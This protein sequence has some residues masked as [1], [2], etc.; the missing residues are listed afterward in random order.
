MAP[1][2]KKDGKPTPGHFFFHL[3]CANF[4]T[5]GHYFLATIEGRFA[6]VSRPG[7]PCGCRVHKHCGADEHRHT[8]FLP[9]SPLASTQILLLLHF[10]NTEARTPKKRKEQG[11]GQKGE[12]RKM[13]TDSKE[14]GDV[15]RRAALQERAAIVRRNRANQPRGDQD[16]HRCDHPFAHTRRRRQSA[17]NPTTAASTTGR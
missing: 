13:S 12:N 6:I 7:Q 16:G 3:A 14:G 4:V 11:Q 17:V 1:K 9:R 5:L 8:T 10:Q 2:G 15:T